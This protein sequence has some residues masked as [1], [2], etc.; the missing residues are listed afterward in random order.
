VLFCKPSLQDIKLRWLRR[1]SAA[2]MS[3]TD[4]DLLTLVERKNKWHL[5]QHIKALKKA[6]K[7]IVAVAKIL[8]ELWA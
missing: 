7:I 2:K 3:V 6:F 8:G 5:I 1:N 4:V